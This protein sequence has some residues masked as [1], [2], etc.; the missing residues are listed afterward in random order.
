MKKITKILSLVVSAILIAVMMTACGEGLDGTASQTAIQMQEKLS[1]EGYKT[2]IEY[3]S[4]ARVSIVTARIELL[5]KYGDKEETFFTDWVSADWYASED[6][7][8]KGYEA[9]KKDGLI[10]KIVG[11]VVYSGT[12]NGVELFEHKIPET[13]D[14]GKQAMQTAGYSVVDVNLSTLETTAKVTKKYK[15]TLGE[16]SIEVFYFDNLEAAADYYSKNKSKNKTKIIQ[17]YGNFVYVGTENAVIAYKGI[18]NKNVEIDGYKA[19]MEALGYTTVNSY[20]NGKAGAI[21]A[22]KKGSEN[23]DLQVA[24]FTDEERAKA[25]YDYLLVLFKD[26]ID[27]N[28]IKVI[29][30]GELLM[31][32]TEQAIADFES[33]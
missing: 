21:K 2:T 8:K 17:K 6:A 9:A 10:F 27:K 4:N 1:N 12:E 30:E 29:H 20:K 18:E 15:A 32:G 31:V 33:K 7:A 22:K 3:N 26:Y 13:V 14:E 23:Y 16:E 19:K 5:F 28:Q 25:S 11:D 24:W